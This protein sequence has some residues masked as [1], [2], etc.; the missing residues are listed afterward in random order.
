MKAEQLMRKHLTPR[1][2]NGC[3]SWTNVHLFRHLLWSVAQSDAMLLLILVVGTFRSSQSGEPL[4][5]SSFAYTWPFTIVVWCTTLSCYPRT[6]SPGICLFWTV[7]FK[8]HSKEELQGA[9]TACL[10]TPAVGDCSRHSHGPIGEWE[11]S[12][13]N[14]LLYHNHKLYVLQHGYELLNHSMKFIYCPI[15]SNRITTGKYLLQVRSPLTPL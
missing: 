1:V 12:N 2:D 4:K 13:I 14:N 7:V 8:P 11:V 9:I 6:H 5:P 15:D 10:D 3:V